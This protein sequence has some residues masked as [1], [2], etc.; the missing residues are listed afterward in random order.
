ME[1]TSVIFFAMGIIIGIEAFFIWR[2]KVLLDEKQ[3]DLHDAKTVL[4]DIRTQRDKLQDELKIYKT[5]RINY[6]IS[7]YR[8]EKN[9]R[10]KME[11]ELKKIKL[12]V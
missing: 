12:K 6:F 1:I 10:E 9:A 7:K 2:I 3:R 11:K 4:S 8:E 5:F